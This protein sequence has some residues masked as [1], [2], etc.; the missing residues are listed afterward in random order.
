M[1][2]LGIGTA[3]RQRSREPHGIVEAGPEHENLQTVVA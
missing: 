3:G 1:A 2:D